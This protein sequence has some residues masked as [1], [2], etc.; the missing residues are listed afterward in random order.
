MPASI[1]KPEYQLLR[2]FLVE[3][4]ERAGLTQT[5]VAQRLQRAQSFVSKYELGERRLDVIDFVQVCDCLG[6]D[7]G[8][9]LRQVLKAKK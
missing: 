1:A 8:E 5:Q 9:L 6:V 3:A 2:Q 4:R 7:P